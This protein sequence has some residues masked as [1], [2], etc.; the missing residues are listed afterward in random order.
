MYVYSRL[1]HTGR[2]TGTNIEPCSRHLIKEK[3][4]C[5]NNGGTHPSQDKTTTTGDGKTDATIKL[6]LCVLGWVWALEFASRDCGVVLFLLYLLLRNRL[7][8]EA[9][10]CC[11]RPSSCLNHTKTQHHSGGDWQ[12]VG[13]W[14]DNS[15]FI[16][17]WSCWQMSPAHH[18]LWFP[19]N[20]RRRRLHA[21]RLPSE[22]QTPA[23]RT[24]YE[25]M[26]W[27]NIKLGLQMMSLKC[28]NV[29]ITC[30]KT[31]KLKV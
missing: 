17:Q 7:T 4:N 27:L 26:L 22:R 9:K 1:L 19:Q 6:K 16:V 18:H 25:L 8:M 10:C 21:W 14:G 31:T 13:V 5:W 3:L 29:Y 20:G 2:S 15:W 30:Y 12:R 23:D 28:Q 24:S 11:C